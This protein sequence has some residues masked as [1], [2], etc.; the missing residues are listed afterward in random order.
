VAFD[1]TI[2]TQ[3]KPPVSYP[4]NRAGHAAASA[5]YN[6]QPTFNPYAY[7]APN[8]GS[9]SGG[10]GGGGG[11]GGYAPP[12]P[13]INALIENN[14][15][16]LAAKALGA[17]Q[18]AALDARIGSNVS[19]ALVNLGDYGLASAVK[20]VNLPAGTEALVDQANKS[21][22]SILARLQRGHEQQQEYIP[23]AL[24]GR[25][26]FRSGQT[27][28]ALGEESRTYGLRQGDSRSQTLDYLNSL[29]E[30]YLN[31]QFGLEQNELNAYLGAYQSALGQLANYG[32]GILFNPQQPTAPPETTRAPNPAAPSTLP[33]TSPV[34]GVP[35]YGSG[36]FQEIAKRL[37]QSRPTGFSAL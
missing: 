23:A 34:A 25:G 18:R 35:G 31:S 19:R 32:G 21:G 10:G 8:Y 24:A 22:T 9:P 36:A 16:Y 2:G 29:Y 7:E 13:D 27:G 4:F 20:D 30:G 14:P 3:Y 6:Q 26:F 5:Y 37:G 33:A 11:G 15:F 17:K 28:H 1:D 12:V